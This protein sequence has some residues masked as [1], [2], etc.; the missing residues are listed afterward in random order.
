M[1][2]TSGSLFL[3]TK[4]DCVHQAC[5]RLYSQVHR[6]EYGLDVPRLLLAVAPEASVALECVGVVSACHQ[7]SC[8]SVVGCSGP[9]WRFGSPLLVP[10]SK[11][12]PAY[13]ASC[14]QDLVLTGNQQ[15][16]AVVSSSALSRG[17]SS[18]CAA[19]SDR[20]IPAAL[21]L[22][23]QEARSISTAF[24]QLQRHHH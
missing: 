22:A 6:V 1:S 9:T 5:M 2:Q 13:R 16:A 21:R 7:I 15:P 20:S 23:L 10:V 19:L 4:L 17:C 11:L 14:W 3:S 24:A 8:C 12:V 18:L